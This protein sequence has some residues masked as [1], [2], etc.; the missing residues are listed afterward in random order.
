[1]TGTK[2]TSWELERFANMSTDTKFAVLFQ[3]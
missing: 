3:E 1:M 2:N